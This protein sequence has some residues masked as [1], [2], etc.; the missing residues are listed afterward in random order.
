MYC[1]LVVLSEPS[2]KHRSSNTFFY[3]RNKS[4]LSEPSKE[5]REETDL[6]EPFLLQFISSL[7]SKN[8]KKPKIFYKKRKA[9]QYFFQWQIFGIVYS[10]LN[11]KIETQFKSKLIRHTKKKIK[12]HQ[13][14]QSFWQEVS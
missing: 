14:Y 3:Y 8:L 9:L 10:T 7:L 13:K 4:T 5:T 2:Q 6:T 12:L 11:K 1:R